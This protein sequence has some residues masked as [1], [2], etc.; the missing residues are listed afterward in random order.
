[1]AHMLGKYY[2]SNST[3]NSHSNSNSN[4]NSTSVLLMVIEQ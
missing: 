3:G 2:T 4:R 1:M